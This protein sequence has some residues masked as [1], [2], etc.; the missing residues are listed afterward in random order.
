MKPIVRTICMSSAR[1]GRPRVAL[2]VV[3]ALSLMMAACSDDTPPPKKDTEA[4]A[5]TGPAIAA[6]DPIAAKA[7]GIVVAVAGPATISETI[8]L[9]GTVRANAEREQNLR[10]RYPG[11]VRLVN[12]RVGDTV[13]RG[14]RLLTVE[15]SESLQSYSI[16]SPIAG[17]VLERHANIGETVDNATVLMRVADLST[18]WVEFAVFARDLGHVRAGLPVRISASDGD[19]R[20]DAQL[21]YVA[22]AG[23]SG[24]QSVTARAEVDNSSG[25]WVS[26]QFVIG[27]LA[28]DQFRAA[29]A[30]TPGAIQ[31]LKG[32]D[33]VFV[34]TPRGFEARAVKVGRRSRNAVEIVSGLAAG[35]RYAAANSYLVKADLLKGEAEEE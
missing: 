6:I 30:V 21:T 34:Q 33:V 11:V 8:T 23:D 13:A 9:Y 18:L 32:H 16:A 29:V 22:P 19:F 1:Q 28:V 7:A 24:N 14:E 27:D 12:K 31:A 15:S 4:T 25:R 20:T 35:E 10:A 5:P 2:I 26:G 3:T 17:T